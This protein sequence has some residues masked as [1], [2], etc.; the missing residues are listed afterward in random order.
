MFVSRATTVLSYRMTLQRY[1]TN[2]RLDRRRK[3]RGLVAVELEE[4]A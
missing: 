2:R 3:P 4:R 1:A